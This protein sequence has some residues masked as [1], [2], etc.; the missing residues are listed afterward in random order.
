MDMAVANLLKRKINFRLTHEENYYRSKELGY[1]S[2]LINKQ[3][4]GDQPTY[5]IYKN[6]VLPFIVHVMS[7]LATEESEDIDRISVFAKWGSSN[8][9]GLGGV[10]MMLET[11]RVNIQQ[12]PSNDDPMVFSDFC[13]VMD[14]SYKIEVE[15]NIRKIPYTPPVR[16]CRVN[17]CAVCR[18]SK[19]NILYLD[20]M[21]V[22]ICDSC[23]GLK[24]TGRKNCDVC[25]AEISTRIAL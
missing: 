23:D 14:E 16:M 1:T 5:W 22:V 11:P 9:R 8:E 24:K 10:V 12:F 4:I 21:H 7:G 15:F 18:E 17:Y 6:S 2:M 20:C 13:P 3:N 19:P 25:R